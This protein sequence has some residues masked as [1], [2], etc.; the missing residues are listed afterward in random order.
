MAS[1]ATYFRSISVRLE[2][3]LSAY[4]FDHLSP[5]VSWL[6]EVTLSLFL[7]VR[8]SSIRSGPLW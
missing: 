5:L 8:Q 2:Y 6:H 4:L 3:Y 1:T 7:R